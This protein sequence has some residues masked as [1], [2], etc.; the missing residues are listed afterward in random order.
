MT[1]CCMLLCRG[2]GRGLVQKLLD[3]DNHV[4][5]TTRSVKEATALQQLAQQHPKLTITELDTSQE[6]SISSWAAHVKQLLPHVDV[7]FLAVSSHHSGSEWCRSIRTQQQ[8]HGATCAPCV[9]V[10]P[11]TVLQWQR[12][13]AT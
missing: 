3:R 2:I 6:T 9:L 7:S 1:S 13:Y 4:V 8:Q 11:M 10:H 5:A 12:L